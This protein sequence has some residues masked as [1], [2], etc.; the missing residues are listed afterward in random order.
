MCEEE[1]LEDLL[2]LLL[3]DNELVLELFFIP[4]KRAA[5]LFL[6]IGVLTVLGLLSNPPNISS[7]LL[8]FL[9]L[10]LSGAAEDKLDVE[11]FDLWNPRNFVQG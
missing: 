10:A 3:L 2:E 11:R 6:I 4:S 9:S 5:V 7:K 1:L 8:V